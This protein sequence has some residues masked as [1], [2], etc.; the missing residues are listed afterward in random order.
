MQREA[1]LTRRTSPL[2]R[3]R[4]AQSDAAKGT[5]LMTDSIGDSSC[6]CGRRKLSP[7]ATVTSPGFQQWVPTPPHCLCPP[8]LFPP[9][10]HAVLTL[11]LTARR[12]PGV[13]HSPRASPDSSTQQAFGA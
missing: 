13:S 9:L 6:L 7:W 8:G 3:L 11:S 5:V 4:D 1:E 2:A 10:L 12:H